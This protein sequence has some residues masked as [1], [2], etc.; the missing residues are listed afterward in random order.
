MASKTSQQC[1]DNHRD[2]NCHDDKL[3]PARVRH[4]PAADPKCVHL[5]GFHSYLLSFWSLTLPER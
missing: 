5:K 2:A 3:E 1:G 4:K